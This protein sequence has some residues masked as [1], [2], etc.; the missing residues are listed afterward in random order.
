MNIGNKIYSA[1]TAANRVTKELTTEEP[2]LIVFDHCTN[3]SVSVNETDINRKVIRTQG[4]YNR[5]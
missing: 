1:E 3:Y 5:I 4:I 2:S